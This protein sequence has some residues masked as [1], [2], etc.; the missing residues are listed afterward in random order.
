MPLEQGS[1]NNTGIVMQAIELARPL[2]GIRCEHG[3]ARALSS[4]HP[5]AIDLT[6]ANQEPLRTLAVPRIR[7]IPYNGKIAEQVTVLWKISLE[8]PYSAETQAAARCDGLSADAAQMASIGVNRLTFS[9]ASF[10]TRSPN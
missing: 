5:F 1:Q 10:T 8:K 9:T 2:V 4:G 7:C 6:G 3:E